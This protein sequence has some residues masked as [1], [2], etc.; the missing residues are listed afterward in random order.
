MWKTDGTATGTGPLAPVEPVS[1][2]VLNGE[3]Y[4]LGVDYPNN[5]ESFGLWTTN[6]TSGGASEV[7]DLG[8]YGDIVS[9]DE[10]P[11]QYEGDMATGGSLVYFTTGSDGYGLDLWASDGTAAGTHVVLSSPQGTSG[12]YNSIGD[13]R[14]F[15][16]KLAFSADS[17]SEGDQVWI[18]DGTAG[19]TQ[20]LTDIPDSDELAFPAAGPSDLTVLGDT[21]YFIAG[22]PN[23]ADGSPG[24]WS[25]DGTMGHTSEFYNFPMLPD[26]ELP[27]SPFTPQA[28][29]LTAVGSNLFFSL[30]YND[31]EFEPSSNQDQG[32]TSTTQAQLWTSNGTASGTFQVPMASSGTTSGLFGFMT[33]GDQALFRAVG[34]GGTA[35]WASDGT[36]AGTMELK[37]LEASTAPDE[38]GYS[39]NTVVNNAIIYF[40][41]DDGTHGTEL[42]QSDGTTAGT[43]MVDDIDP[44]DASSN[45]TPL[46]VING[47]LVLVADDGVDGSEL[48]T[49]TSTPQATA[50][51]LTAVPEQEATAGETFQL[52][53]PLYATDPNEPVLPLTYSLGTDAPA[54]MTID[55]LTGLLTWPGS[56]DRTTGSYSFTVTVD[57]DGTPAA[58]ASET[59]TVDVNPVQPLAVTS[60]PT[61]YITA[62]ETLNLAVSLYATDANQPPF[63]LTYS[64]GTDAP[65][66]M[67]INPDTGLLT[68]PVSS[69]QTTGTYSFA[70]TVNE[71]ATPAQSASGTITVDV[72][73]LEPP[74]VVSIPMQSINSGDTLRLDLRIDFYDPNE[75]PFPLTYSLGANAPEGAS[76]TPAGML[77][78]ASPSGLAT[79]IYTIPVLVTDGATPPQATLVSIRVGVTAI[80]IAAPPVVEPI[81]A[82]S[83][84]DVT[85]DQLSL[86]VDEYAYDP[87]TPQLPL[88]YSLAG[89]PPA[90]VSI[91]SSSGVLTWVVPAGQR[92]GSYPVTLIVTTTSTTPQT[93]SETINL[94]VVDASPPPM[95]STPVVSSRKGFS[96]V[97]RFSVPVDPATASDLANY[98]LT[99]PGKKRKGRKGAAPPPKVI[100]I[101]VRFNQATDKVTLKALEKPKPGAVL[102][103]TIVGSGTG[104]IAKLDG[105][106]L[107]GAGQSG[108]NYVASIRGKKV[109]PVAAV[110]GL[111]ESSAPTTA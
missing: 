98:I 93:T 77:N 100:P 39:T 13:M 44:G 2:A 32:F 63:P 109:S 35:L 25:S 80:S 65:A 106:Q 5:E 43:F 76:I 33:L 103:L 11:D 51:E 95:V 54:G 69:D 31:S 101:Q 36:A 58:S 94:T 91:D 99:E 61:Y 102:T 73:P 72:N 29:N 74:S 4:F 84:L 55:P 104:G 96:I 67:T 71:D 52:P 50:P 37:F 108:T 38:S 10:E 90:G 68:W 30:L 81:P 59:I 40:A 47:Q 26:S 3:A 12:G 75:P 22:N 7:M 86:Q 66:G 92:I 9:S 19:G 62:G 20:M 1:F 28:A 56:S 88:T 14:A 83:V 16:G 27:Q 15:D 79:G 21:L 64:L 17:S 34:S 89:D 107:A 78:W 45:P 41:A 110:A 48:M 53:M 97:V 57:D 105:L 8:Q 18:T 42:W 85:G 23:D 24:L 82:Q 70:V 111:P 6:G 46:A 87:N 60:I 49:L